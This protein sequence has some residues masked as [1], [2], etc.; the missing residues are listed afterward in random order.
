ML[1]YWQMSHFWT[2]LF[3]QMKIPTWIIESKTIKH[4]IIFSGKCKECNSSNLK[5]D[6]CSISPSFPSGPLTFISEEARALRPTYPVRLCTQRP[7][8]CGLYREWN[9]FFLSLTHTHRHRH[10]ETQR[11][12]K[13][14]GRVGERRDEERNV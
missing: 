13:G 4:F 14:R 11:K 1:A 10:T 7:V 2:H 9:S 6:G 3:K 5:I 12:G 8:F